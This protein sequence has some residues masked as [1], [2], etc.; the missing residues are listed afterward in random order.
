MI[1]RSI[2]KVTKNRSTVDDQNEFS[3]KII[4]GSRKLRLVLNIWTIAQGRLAYIPLLN[5]LVCLI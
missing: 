3:F 2:F 5:M 1:Y 4:M